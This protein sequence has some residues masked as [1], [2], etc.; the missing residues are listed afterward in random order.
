[1]Q[2]LVVDDDADILELACE[3][4]AMS[5]IT[6]KPCKT[7]DEALH[8]IA[9]RRYD[10]VVCD[11]VMQGMTGIDFVHELKKRNQMIYPFV[12]ITGYASQNP[13]AEELVAA[14]DVDRIFV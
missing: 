4:F 5:G 7:P 3:L 6:A 1:M 8:A 9:G 11:I 2:I 13:E 12:F 10:A 14:G